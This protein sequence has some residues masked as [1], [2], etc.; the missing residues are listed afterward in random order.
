MDKKLKLKVVTPER[1]LFEQDVDQVTLPTQEGEITVL[2]NHLPLISLIKPGE[3]VFKN[4][5]QTT[6]LVIAG[7]FIEVQPDKVVILADSAEKVEE[8]KE[9][10]AEEARKRAEQAMKEKTIDAKEYAYLV[11]KIEKEMARIKVAKKYRNIRGTKP[12]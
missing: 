5:G 10:R 6:P 8:I 7:G 12:E 2:P 1:V 9:D 3:V 11:S 4:E